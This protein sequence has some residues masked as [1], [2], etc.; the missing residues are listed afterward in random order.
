MRFPLFYHA[1]KKPLD[2]P[3]LKHNE[4]MTELKYGWD[5]DRR[6][7]HLD[8]EVKRGVRWLDHGEEIARI[9]GGAA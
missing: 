7:R 1:P 2:W 4:R 8:D 6:S 5:R 9:R 3:R